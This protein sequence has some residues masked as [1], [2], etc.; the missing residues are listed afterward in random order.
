MIDIQKVIRFYFLLPYEEASWIEVG[1][2]SSS[3]CLKYV[4]KNLL[5]YFRALRFVVNIIYM[6][7]ADRKLPNITLNMEYQVT[8]PKAN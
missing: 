7:F 3:E 2:T 1:E 6:Y 5:Q 4:E 8:D